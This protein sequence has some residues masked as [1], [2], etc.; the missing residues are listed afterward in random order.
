[1]DVGE[2]YLYAVISEK[3]ALTGSTECFVKQTSDD[4]N[5]F[6]IFADVLEW[7]NDFICIKLSWSKFPHFNVFLQET[8]TNKEFV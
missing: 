1:M 5:S 7:K 8:S 4:I 6:F 3:L 2:D